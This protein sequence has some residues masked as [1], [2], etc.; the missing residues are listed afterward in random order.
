VQDGAA[1]AVV[2]LAAGHRVRPPGLA[3]AARVVA[4]H[5]A[6]VPAVAPHRVA[7]AA[8]PAVA[9]HRVALAA[10]PVVAPHRAALAALAVVRAGA[11][12][13]VAAAR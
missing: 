10:V 2:G 8:V 3:R 13:R 5:R 12:G 11:A 1:R 7:L 6:A 4:A 9:P